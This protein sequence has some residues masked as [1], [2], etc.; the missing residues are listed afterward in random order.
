M[1]VD[2]KKIWNAC[3]AAFDRFTSAED[4]FSENIE[5]PVVEELIGEIKG[6]RALDLGCGSGAY[7]IPFAERGAEVAGFDL[8]QTMISLAEEKARERDLIID[9]RV[10]D[11]CKPLPFDDHQFDLVFT[12][13]AL[14]YVDDLS[15]FFREA[16]RV[17]KPEGRMIASVLHPASTALFPPAE[18]VGWALP[19]KPVYFGARLR[20]IETPWLEFGEVADEGRQIISY[21]HT[22]EDY[23][24]ALGAAGLRVSEVREPRPT[25][26]F[27]SKNRVRYLESMRSP[28]YLI[29]KAVV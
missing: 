23:F 19:D 26:D 28:V 10:A 3:G 16:A 15:S 27:A 13:T 1:T 21:H 6:W 5:R 2:A 8:S 24:I 20:K 12:A 17:M 14:H 4:S 22:L 11:I 18:S 9:F 7:S 25:E 29:F